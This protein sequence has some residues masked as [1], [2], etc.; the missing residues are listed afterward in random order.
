M[1][2]G[3]S[4]LTASQA[5]RGQMESSSSQADN[6]TSA[7][8]KYVTVTEGDTVY[9]YIVIGKNMKILIGKSAVKEDDKDEKSADGKNKNEATATSTKPNAD[10]QATANKQAAEKM[11]FLNDYRM[12]GLTGYYQK[13]MRE[14]MENM[15]NQ[16]GSNKV[17]TITTSPITKHTTE[18]Q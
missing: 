14:T 2:S 10:P 18:D 5:V 15:E 11:N 16:L 17:D 7:G 8:W 13:K 3:I 9:T 4:S 12:L 6:S 1:L